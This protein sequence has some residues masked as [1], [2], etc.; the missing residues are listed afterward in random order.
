MRAE[1]GVGSVG[2]ASALLAT[3]SR[4]PPTRP[5]GTSGGCVWASSAWGPFLASGRP[6]A[7]GFP[8]PASAQGIRPPVRH[9]RPCGPKSFG[10]HRRL[11]V[12]EARRTRSRRVWQVLHRRV[13]V[14]E[15]E[16][17]RE[18]SGLR[19]RVR[20]CA[21]LMRNCR[22]R[23]PSAAG[24]RFVPGATGFADHHATRT[25]ARPPGSEVMRVFTHRVGT[26]ARARAQRI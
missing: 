19:V 12:M 6:S 3:R 8:R 9:H 5:T 7:G 11:A 22:T 18:F 15:S 2:V 24:T 23:S 14:C 10:A 1:P 4:D 17:S 13:P 20:S 26:F 16:G 21:G 25:A